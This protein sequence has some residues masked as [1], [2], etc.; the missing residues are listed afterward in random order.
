MSNP[1]IE[2]MLCSTG[3]STILTSKDDD[4]PFFNF[5]IAQEKLD[6]HRAIMV[7]K[8]NE[9]WFY[10]R[11]NS[12][13]TGEKEDNTGKLPYL[14]LINFNNIIG[15]D[16][17]I[18]DGE[19]TVLGESSNSSKV[20]H[21]LGSTPERAF[22]LWERGYQL[23]YNIFDVIKWDG[24]WQVNLPLIDRLR[25][26]EIV[27]RKLDELPVYLNIRVVDSYGH[28]ELIEHYNSSIK[29]CDDFEQLLESVYERGGEGIVLK[30]ALAKY[31]FKRSKYWQKFK[32]IN[33]AD[34]VIMGFVKPKKEYTGKFSKDEL[35]TLG[36]KYWENDEPVSKTYYNKWVAGIK[37]GAYKDGELK[38]VTTVKGF[39]DEVQKMILNT[40][41]YN[42][43][44]EIEYQS[45]IDKEKKSLRHPRF[46]AFRFDKR[47]EDCLWEN[48]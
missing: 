47:N 20:Q 35:K 8:N 9:N 37:L 3:L 33:T 13:V 15:V 5:W 16:D 6:G 27:K 1:N 42:V 2:P 4:Y 32:K 44:V 29:E 22:E 36:W 30:Y 48:V 23:C 26:I 21:I 38:Y 12:V 25:F 41:L 40:D 46:K 45:I 11:R 14:K 31:E 39:S 43:P 17:C 19:L 28:K 7:S 34:L 18:F 24:Q 10:S